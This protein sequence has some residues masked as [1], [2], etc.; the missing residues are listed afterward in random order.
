[1]SWRCYVADMLVGNDQTEADSCLEV[2][3][4]LLLVGWGMAVCGAG[5][6]QNQP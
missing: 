1:M 5:M 3:M 4:R 2:W 6:A